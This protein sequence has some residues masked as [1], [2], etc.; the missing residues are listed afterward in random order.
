MRHQIR[1]LTRKLRTTTRRSEGLM[2]RDRKQLDLDG[3]SLFVLKSSIA[4]EHL[5]C[6]QRVKI[7]VIIQFDLRF[8]LH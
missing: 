8:P 5:Q 3:S 7:T 4:W 2:L 1:P 6:S